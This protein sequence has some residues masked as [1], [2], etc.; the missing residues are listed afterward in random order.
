MR[1]APL[2][3][4]P[5]PIREALLESFPALRQHADTAEVLWLAHSDFPRV[6]L[7]DVAAGHL[8]VILSPR[9]WRFSHGE[10]EQQIHPFEPVLVLRRLRLPSRPTPVP[11]PARARLRSRSRASVALSLA[12]AALLGLVLGL[13]TPRSWSTLE[14]TQ[15][16]QE[17]WQQEA[18]LIELLD[19]ARPA[20]VVE[21]LRLAEHHPSERVRAAV[22]RLRLRTGR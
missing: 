13:S 19:Q 22:E 6:R 11:V 14:A 18:A 10:E 1:H 15:R 17:V 4:L 9:P 20:D 7:E 12:V 5:D 8:R 2:A 16:F 21:I 3:E